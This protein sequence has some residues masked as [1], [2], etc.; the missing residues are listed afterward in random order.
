MQQTFWDKYSMMLPLLQEG[1]FDNMSTVTASHST[2]D[3]KTIARTAILIALLIALQ[4]ATRPLGQLVTG[5]CVNLILAVSALLCGAVSG[6]IVAIV[7][8]FFAYLLGISP[9]IWLAPAI[10]CGNAAFVLILALLGRK[11]G[12]IRGGAAGVV[13]AALCKFAVLNVLVVRLLIPMGN[14]PAKVAA[15]FSWPQLVTALVGGCLAL[16]IVPQLKKALKD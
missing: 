9:Q 8:P 11:L 3:T 4:Y 1:V 15:Q 7:S 16:A 6:C 5:S 10:A 2:L 14:L 12:G 13:A